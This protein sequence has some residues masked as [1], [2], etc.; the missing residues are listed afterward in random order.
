MD[1]IDKEDLYQE[2]VQLVA[3]ADNKTYLKMIDDI[4][5]DSM[6]DEI[7]DHLQGWDK[8]SLEGFIKCYKKRS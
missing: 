1:K 4:F 5:G 2:A 8:V 7:L 6:I 3:N